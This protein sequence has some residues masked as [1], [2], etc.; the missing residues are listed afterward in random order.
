MNL[1]RIETPLVL[2]AAFAM[3]TTLLVLVAFDQ[4]YYEH[5]PRQ[6]DPDFGRLYPKVI[7]HGTQVYMT[8]GEKLLFEYGWIPAGLIFATAW[9]IRMRNAKVSQKNG[10][11]SP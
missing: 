6:P 8:R 2:L 9:V 11:E 3:V 4:Y 1:R 5:C 10:E 7:H